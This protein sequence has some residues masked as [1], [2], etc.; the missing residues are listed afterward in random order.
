MN[1]R[2]VS[3]GMICLFLFFSIG[4]DITQLYSTGGATAPYIIYYEN[5]VIRTICL[6]SI[7][8]QVMILTMSLLSAINH[9]INE[10]Y[11]LHRIFVQSPSV[12]I[13]FLVWFEFYYGSTFY[14]GEV[15]DK[16]MILYTANSM[17]ILGTSILLTF[18]YTLTKSFIRKNRIQ[19]FAYSFIVFVIV[20]S[21]QYSIFKLLEDKWKL[22]GS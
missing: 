22:W 17:G 8:L 9:K 5:S 16:Q 15:R 13:I 12:I 20:L 1:L 18:A 21:I 7:I 3:Y 4:I 10:S 6:T 2:L 14:Y 19:K 11:S